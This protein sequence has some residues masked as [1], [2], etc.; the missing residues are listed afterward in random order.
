VEGGTGKESATRKGSIKSNIYFRH[1]RYLSQKG[2]KVT[3][4]SQ[5]PETKKRPSGERA[6]ELRR[7]CRGV[8]GGY[9]W[10]VMVSHCKS[11]PSSLPMKSMR[12][13]G[14]KHKHVIE[15]CVACLAQ[16]PMPDVSPGAP[17]TDVVGGVVG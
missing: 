4:L 8:R 6:R 14:E 10:E 2:Q 5:L 13:L 1:P 16:R 15:L 7:P 12:P 11:S 17:A 3:L 9:S